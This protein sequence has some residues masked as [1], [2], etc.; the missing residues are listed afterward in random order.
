M[1]L[2]QHEEEGEMIIDGW[3]LLVAVVVILALVYF[4]AGAV[5]EKWHDS[6]WKHV[7]KNINLGGNSNGKKKD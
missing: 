6:K 7:R 5:I 3:T 1:G 2:G 4:L